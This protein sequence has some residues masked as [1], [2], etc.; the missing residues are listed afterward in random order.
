M[1]FTRLE[2]IKHPRSLN[3]GVTS[4]KVESLEVFRNPISLVKRVIEKPYKFQVNCGALNKGFGP[5]LLLKYLRARKISIL[6]SLA[7]SLTTGPV[8]PAIF[9]Q[10][11]LGYDY[12]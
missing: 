3:R 5:K 8:L 9:H 11:Y 7:N 2:L 1:A 6:K 10:Q 12:L 4:V